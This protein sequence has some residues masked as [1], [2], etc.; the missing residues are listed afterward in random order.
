MFIVE[1]WPES[2]IHTLKCQLFVYVCWKIILL[3]AFLI[4]NFCCIR[5]IIFSYLFCTILKNN[6]KANILQESSHF[7]LLKMY[8]TLVMRQVKLDCID[9]KDKLLLNW[10]NS[11]LKCQYKHYNFFQKEYWLVERVVSNAWV[12]KVKL[13]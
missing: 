9:L 8:Y 13:C 2:Y 6:N 10:E 3:L 12:F 5:L 7:K 4:Q 1:I 11:C